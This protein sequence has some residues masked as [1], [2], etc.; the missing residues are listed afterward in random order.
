MNDYLREAGFLKVD[1]VG[2]FGL[3][4]DTSDFKP[5]GFPISLNVIAVK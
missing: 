5:Y 4:N 3:F 1:K 2:S